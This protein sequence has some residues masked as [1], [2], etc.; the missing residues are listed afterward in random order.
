MFPKKKFSQGDSAKGRQASTEA[1]KCHLLFLYNNDT[2]FGLCFCTSSMCGGM[3][4][5]SA[6]IKFDP[7]GWW[8]F[9]IQGHFKVDGLSFFVFFSWAKF[10]GT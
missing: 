1:G 2:Y 3:Q 8:G 9:S 5:G 10:K 4:N 7:G 6:E